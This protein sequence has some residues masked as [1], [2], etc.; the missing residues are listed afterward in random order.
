ME[1]LLKHVQS[2]W[3]TSS[4]LSIQTGFSRSFIHSFIRSFI[5]S[6]FKAFIHGSFF[7]LKLCEVSL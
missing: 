7:F 3:M 5:H 6:G 4:E 2:Y 1:F